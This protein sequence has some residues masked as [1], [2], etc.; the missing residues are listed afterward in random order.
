MNGISLFSLGLRLR[1]YKGYSKT[2][3]YEVY[4]ALFLFLA[5]V[6]V[7]ANGPI[8][9]PSRLSFDFLALVA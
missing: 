2:I 5:Y 3:F 9:S 8:S 1:T 4:T 6:C 7:H